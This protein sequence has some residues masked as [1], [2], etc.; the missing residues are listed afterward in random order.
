MSFNHLENEIIRPVFNEP[1][2][3]FALNCAAASCPPLRDEAYVGSKLDAQLTEQTKA[4]VNTN[5]HGVQVQGR[6]AK[7]S[8]IFNW[9]S[10]D[11]GDVK[12]F[13]N[14]YRDEALPRFGKLNYLDYDWTR[15]DA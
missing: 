11:F 1:R 2:I 15:N 3:H 4:F 12:Q 7:V 8:Q 10:G 5:P 6:S 14:Q 13:I 9:F